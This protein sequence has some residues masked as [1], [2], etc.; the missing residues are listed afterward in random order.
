MKKTILIIGGAA[1]VLAVLIFVRATAQVGGCNTSSDS[2]IGYANGNNPVTINLNDPNAIQGIEIDDESGNLELRLKE[3]GANFLPG[4][5]Y[6]VSSNYRLAAAAADFNAD[7]FVDLV[8]GGMQTDYSTTAGQGNSNPTDTNISFFLLRGQDPADTTRFLVEGPYYFHYES[9]TAANKFTGTYQMLNVGAGDYDGDGD[10]DIAAM[11]WSGRL[12]LFKNLYVENGDSPGGLPDFDVDPWADLGDLL[13][14]NSR[15]SPPEWN[16]GDD[17]THHR[18]NSSIQSFDIDGDGDLDLIVGVGSRFAYNSEGGYGELV[19]F[20]NNGT[21]TFSRLPTAINPYPNN[22]NNKNGVTGVAC[23]DF[24]GDGDIDFYLG[25]STN[26]NVYMYR[27]DG[28]GNYSQ[29]NPRTYQIANN[30]G[31]T[32]SLGT[33]DFDGDGDADLVLATDA[34]AGV[35]TGS[36]WTAGYCVWF[37]NDGTGVM[38]E[39]CVPSTCTRISSSG[40]LD[41]LAVGDFDNDGDYDFMIADGNDSMNTYFIMNDTFPLYVDQGSAHSINLLPCSFVSSDHAVVAATIT[42]S[43]S[44]PS[45]TTITYY[46]SNNNDENGN[47][48]WEGPVTP[49][50][51]FMFESPGWFLRWRAVLT[52]SDETRT[53]RIFRIDMNYRY[54]NKR[55]Y[56]RTSHAFTYAE[57]NAGHDGNEEVLFSASFEFPSWRGH[58][59]SWDL[60]DLTLTPSQGSTLQEIKGANASYVA[61]AGDVLAGTSYNGRQVFTAEDADSGGVMNDRLEFN[62][63]QAVELEPYL[64]LG[65]GSPETVPLIEFVLGRGRNWK[66]GDINHSSPQVLEPPKGIPSL[67]GESASYDAFK[68]TYENRPRSILVGANDGM[69]HCFHP[70]S[71]E[72]Q[73]AF[74]PNN[75]LYKLKKMR[76]TDPDCGAYLFHHYFV[77]GTA[78]VADVYYDGAWHTVVV[79]GQGPGWGKNHGW[80]Y[81]CLDV[82]DPATSPVPLWEFND[83]A[84]TGETWSVP[85]VGRLPYNGQWVAFFGSGYDSD[86]DASV[87][88]G[89]HFYCVDIETGSVLFNEEVKD[90]PEPASPFGIQNT[91]PGAPAMADI[92]NDGAVDAVYFGD[93]LGRI[94]KI[95]TTSNPSG[96]NP[97][98]IYE[99]PYLHPIVTKPAIAVDKSDKSVHIYFGTGGDEAAPSDVSYSF[100]AL[101]DTG[102]SQAVEWFIGTTDFATAAG[103]DSG[104][105]MDTFGVG[106]KV[107][108]DDIISD[109]I[110]Y[111]ATVS[112]SIENINPCMTLGGSGEIYARY[113]TGSRAGSSALMNS[114]GTAIVSLATLQ[115]VRSAVTIG[116]TS[117]VEGQTKRKVFIQSY[118][119][120]SGDGT[121]EPPSEVLAQ[122]IT[123][124]SKLRIKSWREVYRIIR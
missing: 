2:V 13:G 54:V 86:G 124:Q 100:I 111:I 8:E 25:S 78:T 102:I 14:D 104:L 93:L 79:S 34:A 118:T 101:R 26:R 27:N 97:K 71:L 3:K 70:A 96:W 76:I 29:Y 115:K 38:T 77:D 117:S 87:D 48:S 52:T 23:A 81:F 28:L 110:V 103:I 91:L 95:D 83:P 21:G 55:E 85:A 4:G 80:Y 63:S 1:L 9:S 121:D 66:L 16:I 61:D 5:D 88:L 116:T 11:S 24:D 90:S 75:L 114:T 32:S 108:A 109:G 92:D 68:S 82:T 42:V 7:G 123:P 30:H 99:D 120:P 58:L 89:N 112:G 57:V 105:R 18:W 43:D 39:N 98:V 122:P 62:A 35:N 51:E 20:I 113:T 47:P 69:L 31:T 60:T 84:S 50:V 10:A 119:S 12:M 22:N 33:A 106:E 46:L 45:G 107:W 15:Y 53:P 59:R 65:V 72:E 40:D 17:G 73:W 6:P 49:G 36:P 74:I 56:S 94:W 44:T 41:S 37:R 67:M 64:G 19:I